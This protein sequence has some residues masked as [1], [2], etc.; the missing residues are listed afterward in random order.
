MIN[1]KQFMLGAALVGLPLHGLQLYFGSVDGTDDWW[2]W[3]GLSMSVIWLTLHFW[4]AKKPT[5]KAK[6]EKYTA[7]NPWGEE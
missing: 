7:K 4:P 6:P 1:M 5:E 3:L 2:H